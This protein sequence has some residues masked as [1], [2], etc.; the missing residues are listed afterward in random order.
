MPIRTASYL[1]P[2]TYS[3]DVFRAGLFGVVNQFNI[4][5]LGV[6]TIEAVAMFGLAALAFRRI[7][8]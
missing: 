7:R 3:T 8:V 6:L 5:E 2:L 4:L 1:N